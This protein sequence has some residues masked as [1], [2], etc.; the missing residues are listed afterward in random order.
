MKLMQDQELLK[1]FILMSL[2]NEELPPEQRE[3]KR[4]GSPRSRFR[5]HRQ[6]SHVRVFP[7]GGSR[8][9]V[10]SRR[11]SRPEQARAPFFKD[12]KLEHQAARRRARLRG[13]PPRSFPGSEPTAGC[14]V[15]IPAAPRGI[16]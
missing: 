8:V 13:L 5:R 6:G 4:C 12:D 2:I 1:A 10:D 15:P 16:A 3:N 11:A 14:P 7:R 9:Q